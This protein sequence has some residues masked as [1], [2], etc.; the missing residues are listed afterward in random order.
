MVE[1]GAAGEE[2]LG[3]A[4]NDPDGIVVSAV[5]GSLETRIEIVRMIGVEP[6]RRTPPPLSRGAS[7]VHLTPLDVPN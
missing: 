1:D 6:A 3:I 7:T 5:E 4:E 2:V